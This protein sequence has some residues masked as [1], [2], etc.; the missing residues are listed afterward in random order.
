MEVGVGGCGGQGGSGSDG[1]HGGKGVTWGIIDSLRQVQVPLVPLDWV[2]RTGRAPRPALTLTQTEGV[3]GQGKSPCQ[4]QLRVHRREHPGLQQWRRQAPAGPLQ[5]PCSGGA[6]RVRY[7]HSLQHPRPKHQRQGQGLLL[8]PQT[9]LS[10][11]QQQPLAPL[12]PP[13]RPQHEWQQL[14]VEPL[15]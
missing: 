14:R 1:A 4:P 13:W 7:S 9:A 10:L 3:P 11:P 5:P 15:R 12:H 6:P 8:V 2:P